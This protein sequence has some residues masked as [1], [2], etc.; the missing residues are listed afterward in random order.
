MSSS[1]MVFSAAD[2]TANAEWIGQVVYLVEGVA[3]LMFVALM[4]TAAR[5]YVYLRTGRKQEA[6][7]VAGLGAGVAIVVM[8]SVGVLVF[9]A[10]S[11]DAPASAPTGL[12]VLLL[13]ALLVATLANM[14]VLVLRRRRTR[15]AK[16]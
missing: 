9:V 2:A 16:R 14:A 11:T 10:G 15:E 1:T 7:G 4:V 8:S 6:V 12:Q 3:Q 13:V 5:A